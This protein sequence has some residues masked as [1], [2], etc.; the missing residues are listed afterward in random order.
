MYGNTWNKT[1][2]FLL[3]TPSYT[4]KPLSGLARRLKRPSKE[5]NAVVESKHSVVILNIILGQQVVQLFG[6]GNVWQIYVAP[7]ISGR[8]RVG[9]FIYLIQ[10]FDFDWLVL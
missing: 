1:E 4:N 3:F 8:Q 5:L 10:S 9:L 7:I 2:E 6:L